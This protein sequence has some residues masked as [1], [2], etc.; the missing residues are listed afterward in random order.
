MMDDWICPEEEDNEISSQN[1]FSPVSHK[2]GHATN[3]TGVRNEGGPIQS[4][5]LA[6]EAGFHCQ[7]GTKSPPPQRTA[8][9]F[10]NIIVDTENDGGFCKILPS[11]PL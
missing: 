3:T 5:L 7:H 11:L 8:V 10:L 9:P 2:S 6:Q 1:I 4:K